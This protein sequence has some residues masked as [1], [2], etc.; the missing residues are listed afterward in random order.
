M[1]KTIFD[2]FFDEIVLNEMKQK[3]IDMVEDKEMDDMPLDDIFQG[4]TRKILNMENT[5]I[6]DNL[7]KDLRSIHG[8]FD[9]DINNQKVKRKVKIK[10]P[11]GE[12]EKD[13]EISIG[14]A[15]NLLK[16]PE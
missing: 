4:K 7:K 11:T 14:K 1:S 9:I 15:I 10:S 8:L 12:G 16:I 2:N 3:F 5:V 6:Y 13:Q